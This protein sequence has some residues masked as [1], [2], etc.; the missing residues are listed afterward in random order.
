MPRVAEIA[1]GPARPGYDALRAGA[2]LLDRSGRGRWRFTGPKAAETLTGLVTNDVLALQAGEGLYAAALTPKGKIVADLRI[3]RDGDEFLVDTGAAAAPGWSAMARKYINPRVAPFREATA[4]TADVGVIEDGGCVLE[5]L[6]PHAHARV[7]FKRAGAEALVIRAVE[8][9]EIPGFDIIASG[10]SAGA[11]SAE[12]ESLGATVASPEVFTVA[13][14]EAG[15]PEWGVAMNG[16]TLAQE[17]NL[18]E[19]G[20]MSYAK[21]CYVGQEVGSRSHCRGHVNRTLRRISFDADQVPPR[22]TELVDAGGKTVGDT[23]S[24]AVS[25]RSGGVGIAMVRREI[26]AGAELTARWGDA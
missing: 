5:Q 13:R 23:R 4:E 6:R 16:G 10:E 21:G 12:L 7:R 25:P 17:A 11:I 20:A 19:L 24:T 2:A 14:V 8:L 26:E 9:G 15:V 3:L 22:G 1:G 18:D